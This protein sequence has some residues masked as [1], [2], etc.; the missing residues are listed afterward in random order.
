MPG[1]SG[2]VETFRLSTNVRVAK[3][4]A[5][6]IDATDSTQTKFFCSVPP[7]TTPYNYPCAGITLEHYVEP[8]VFYPEDTDPTTITGVA[9]TAP[10]VLG[11]TGVALD[12][13]IPLVGNGAQMQRV[14]AAGAINAGDI[15]VIADQYGR[16]NNLSN[17]SLSSGQAF[18]VGI[19]V[20]K[21][22]AANQVL[23]VNTMFM[24]VTAPQA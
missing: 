5:L 14:Y 7:S 16:V 11:G 15:V 9:P 13:G 3:F 23:F 4:S 24:Q 8:N 12:R 19:A 1:I 20:S 17:L 2:F 6:I 22:T 10:Y 18:P 21:T